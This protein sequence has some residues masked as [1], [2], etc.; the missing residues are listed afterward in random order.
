LLFKEGNLAKNYSYTPNRTAIHFEMT[1][2]TY[3]DH[4][5]TNLN[6]TGIGEME[7]TINDTLPVACNNENTT[8]SWLDKCVLAKDNVK[9]KWEAAD[10]LECVVKFLR[11]ED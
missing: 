4:F 3:H 10:I 1:D 8:V 6:E 9:I 11:V 7:I 5:I 2:G